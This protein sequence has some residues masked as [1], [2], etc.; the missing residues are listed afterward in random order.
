M[1]RTL[2]WINLGGVLAL[3]VLSGWQWQTNRQLNHEVQRIEGMRLKQIEELEQKEQALAG[4]RADLEVFRKSI[5]DSGESLTSARDQAAKVGRELAQAARDREELKAAV[6]K[7]SEAVQ[8]RDEQIKKGNQD[9]ESLVKQRNDAV[10]QLNALV[11][12]YDQL[13]LELNA[14]TEKYNAL[15]TELNQKNSKKQ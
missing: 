6:A 7:W 1:N 12:K 8:L 13:V 10:D 4:Y 5:T 14:R 9:L 15:V 2:Q 3:A 11:K